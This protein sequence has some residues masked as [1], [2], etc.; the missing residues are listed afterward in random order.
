[1]QMVEATDLPPLDRACI[2][3]L[4]I[5]WPNEGDYGQ[6]DGRGKVVNGEIAVADAETDSAAAVAELTQVLYLK[7]QRKETEIR[8]RTAPLANGQI[9]K[10]MPRPAS[11]ERAATEWLLTH[12]PTDWPTP[13]CLNN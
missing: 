8:R 4:K 11:I 1:M 5:D 2:L 13:F 6:T 7:V 9:G 3:A 10:L 12:R